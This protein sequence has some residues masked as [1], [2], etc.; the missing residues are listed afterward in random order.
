[1]R[2]ASGDQIPGVRGGSHVPH[3]P[4]VVMVTR[5][6][7]LSELLVQLEQVNLTGVW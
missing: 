5:V 3:F 1:M 2:M 6:V 7:Q 4:L